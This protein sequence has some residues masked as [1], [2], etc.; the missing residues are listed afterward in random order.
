MASYATFDVRFLAQYAFMR[1]LTLRRSAE[2][3]GFLFSRVAN[4]GDVTPNATRAF[5]TARI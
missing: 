5:L 1:L 3:I 4:L 2:D